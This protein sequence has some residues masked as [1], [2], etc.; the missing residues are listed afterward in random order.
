MP[1]PSV[2]C[3][4]GWFR[5][6]SGRMVWGCLWKGKGLGIRHSYTSDSWS[7]GQRCPKVLRRGGVRSQ[8]LQR[9]RCLL[10]I[11]GGTL[12]SSQL[13]ALQRG[14]GSGHTHTP[15]GCS[16]ANVAD[17]SHEIGFS[18]KREGRKM[19]MHLA[20]V[21]SFQHKQAFLASPR[22]YRGFGVRLTLDSKC[23]DCLFSRVSVL[24]PT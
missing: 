16:W 7:R 3:G 24:R 4:I 20:T 10:I 14:P 6:F 13:P 8:F 15:T 11:G 23:P 1:F 2:N 5:P 22:A 18:G 9:G 17:V 12:F 21:H 19:D